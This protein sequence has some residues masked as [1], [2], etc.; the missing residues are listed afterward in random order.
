MIELT[1]IDGSKFYLNVFWIEQVRDR[2]TRT[3]VILT[4]KVSVLCTENAKQVS[5]RIAFIQASMSGA[6]NKHGNFIP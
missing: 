5:N 3:E 4:N 2:V 1:D 6:L